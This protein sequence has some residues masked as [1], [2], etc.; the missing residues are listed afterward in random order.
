MVYVLQNELAW[1]RDYLFNRRQI[2]SY[3][4]IL[5]DPEPVVCGIPQGLIS[6]PQMFLIFFNDFD[7]SLQYSNSVVFADDTVIYYEN[8]SFEIIQ[9][10]LNKEMV[11]IASYFTQNELVINLKKNKTESMLFGTAKKLSKTAVLEIYYN[12]HLINHTTRYKYLGT[13]LDPT[14]NLDDHFASVYKKASSR[15]R[16]L[17]K[18]R[19]NLTT[20]AFEGVYNMMVVP[21]FLFNCD[22]CL[23]F[24]DT[25]SRN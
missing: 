8:K 14:L 25:H 5:S 18:L 24:T 19:E 1:F 3:D 4:G 23:N 12:H 17:S 20:S 21:L 2:V 15:L 6:G 10:R 11:S 16:L 9:K 22:T 7:E 13:V